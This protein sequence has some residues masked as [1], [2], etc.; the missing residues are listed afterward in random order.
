MHRAGAIAFGKN[1]AGS[2]SPAYLQSGTPTGTSPFPYARY[3]KLGRRTFVADNIF[4]VQFL[5]FQAV[6]QVVIGVRSAV[7]GFD[8]RIEFGMFCL[9]CSHV[10][11]IHRD[12]LFLLDLK[13]S[14]SR[15]RLIVRI[16][17]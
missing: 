13:R 10:T 17:E 16:D 1:L 7:F 6:D 9:Q 11:I 5:L 2:V 14:F 12:L 15:I 4:Q 8:L 3:F